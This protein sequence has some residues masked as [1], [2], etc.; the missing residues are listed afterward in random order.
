[1]DKTLL[2]EIFRNEAMRTKGHI[3][4]SYWAIARHSGKP[5]PMD[6]ELYGRF[7][8][9]EEANEEQRFMGGKVVFVTQSTN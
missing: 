7:M 5:H 2:I 1:M 4:E 6:T 8:T 3:S 9:M